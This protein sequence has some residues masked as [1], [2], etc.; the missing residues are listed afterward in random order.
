MTITDAN[1]LHLRNIL[2]C[3]SDVRVTQLEGPRPALQAAPVGAYVYVHTCK[4]EYE[5][6]NL[7]G[8]RILN[9]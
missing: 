4:G 6:E 8:Y 1:L 3:P 7:R 2:Q 9:I 5:P